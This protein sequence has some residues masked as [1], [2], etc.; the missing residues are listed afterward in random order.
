MSTRY[1]SND[2][3]KLTYVGE[4]KTFQEAMFID[5]KKEQLKV[6]QDEMQSSY[7][8]HTYKLVKFP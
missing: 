4:T 7:K 5:H 1:A 6:I 2:Y 3:V 8:N